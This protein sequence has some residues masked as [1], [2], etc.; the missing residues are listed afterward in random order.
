[1]TL[2]VREDALVRF[3]EQLRQIDGYTAARNNPFDVG[4]GELPALI[5][6]DGG[7]DVEDTDTNTLHVRLRVGVVCLVSA[8]RAEQLGPALSDARARV[9]SALGTDPTLGGLAMIVRYVGCGD[10][11]LVP[12]EGA[13]PTIGMALDFT[14]ELQE[15]EFDP[16]TQQPS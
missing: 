11:E 6:M 15:A 12:D 16:Y 8:A 9:R 4:A 7:E 10:P 1:M 13:R 14:V 5:Q 3:F 2:S